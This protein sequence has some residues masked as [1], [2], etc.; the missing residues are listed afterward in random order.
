MDDEFQELYDTIDEIINEDSDSSDENEGQKPKKPYNMNY[1]YQCQRLATFK[2][3]PLEKPTPLQ[4]ADAGLYSVS[5]SDHVRCFNCNG[6]IRNWR[7]DDEPKSL[8]KLFF[9]KCTLVGEMVESEDV[10]KC[11]VCKEA[12]VKLAFIPCGHTACFG[13]SYRLETC[14]TC[15]K[16]IKDY[17]R[18]YI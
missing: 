5:L 9:P 6:G 13:C 17:L 18:I 4:L 15:R 12:G 14:H 10:K 2:D 16:R 8:H 3:W 1:F 11:D 7:E